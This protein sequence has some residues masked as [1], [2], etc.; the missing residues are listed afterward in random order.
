MIFAYSF[1]QFNFGN[2]VQKGSKIYHGAL[3]RKSKAKEF[4]MHSQIVSQVSHYID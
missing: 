2:L 3:L 1:Y 4:K